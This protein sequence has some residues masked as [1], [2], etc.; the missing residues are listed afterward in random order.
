MLYI[1]SLTSEGC[2]SSQNEI[3][4]RICSLQT[5]PF[6]NL[7]TS[8]NKSL[9]NLSTVEIADPLHDFLAMVLYCDSATLPARFTRRY[10]LSALQNVVD[11]IRFN[12][13]A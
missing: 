6:E 2:W 11:G 1:N 13:F 9:H 12:L 4:A 10:I 8:L 7:V 3:Q 5:V